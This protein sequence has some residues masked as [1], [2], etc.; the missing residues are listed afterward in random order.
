MRDILRLV[1]GDGGSRKAEP[2]EGAWDEPGRRANPADSR[3]WCGS[4]PGDEAIRQLAAQLRGGA[5]RGPKGAH[6]KVAGRGR[7]AISFGSP[8]L[9]GTYRAGPLM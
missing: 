9:G 4:G 7:L 1:L 3:E 2:G 6:R 8:S 5:R